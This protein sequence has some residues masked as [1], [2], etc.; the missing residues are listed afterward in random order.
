LRTVGWHRHGHQEVKLRVL[1]DLREQFLGE[2]LGVGQ[3]Q[4]AG[5]LRLQNGTC[6][7]EQFRGGLGD[8]SSRC[9]RRE[10]DRLGRIRIEDKEGLRPL[11]W[12][13]RVVFAMATH[14]AFAVA[15]YPMRVDDQ[16]C[17]L[18]VSGGAPQEAECHLKPLR[19]SDRA[20]A[21][22]VMDREVGDDERQPVEQFEPLLAQSPLLADASDT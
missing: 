19:V 14:L 20:G 11:G 1:V 4:H 21:Q 6:Q 2:V 18:I 9:P 17:P 10:T 22:E 16:P 12:A 5:G 7:L 3:D 8:G 15:A 13:G